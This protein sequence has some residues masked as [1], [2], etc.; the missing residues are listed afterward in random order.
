MINGGPIDVSWPK[1]NIRGII[2]AWYPGG[3]IFGCT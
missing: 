2:E 3:M 1:D